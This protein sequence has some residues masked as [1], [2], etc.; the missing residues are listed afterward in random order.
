MEQI[1]IYLVEMPYKRDYL[2][3]RGTV[4]KSGEIKPVEDLQ[5][6]IFVAG[7]VLCGLGPQRFAPLMFCLPMQSHAKPGWAQKRG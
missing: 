7:S 4:V 3:K 1:L 6:I 5:N 2:S